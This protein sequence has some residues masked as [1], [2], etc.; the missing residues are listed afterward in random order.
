MF[1]SAATRHR[2]EQILASRAAGIRVLG[3]GKEGQDTVLINAVNDYLDDTR[4]TKKP[5][6]YA[7]Y[8]T[9]RDYFLESCSKRRFLIEVDRRDV[10][11]YSAFLRD[12]K[13]Q[14]R[15]AC[16]TRFENVMSFLKAAGIRG[17]VN[18]N[19]WP[20][21]VEEEPEIYEQ[22]ELDKFLA[23]C[24]ADERVYFEFFPMTGMREQEVEGGRILAAQIPG[25]ICDRAS[26]ERRGSAHCAILAWPQGSQ[27]HNAV[28]EAESRPGGKG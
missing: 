6:T 10:L 9:A 23:T 28:S 21:F 25:G 5:K 26:V 12:E 15:A 18:K 8:K 1:R 27:I 14:L 20:R 13:N 22:N 24:S 2:Q 16:T 3:D 4:L 19:D 11:Q 17:L 7:A